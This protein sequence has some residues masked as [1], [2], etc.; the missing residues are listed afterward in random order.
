[1][2]KRFKDKLRQLHDE[3]KEHPFWKTLSNEIR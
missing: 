2:E 3:I 1:M